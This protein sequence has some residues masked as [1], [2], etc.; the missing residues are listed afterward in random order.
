MTDKVYITTKSPFD[1][2]FDSVEENRNDKKNISEYASPINSVI[3]NVNEST[4]GA[5]EK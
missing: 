1:T 4:K 2:D 5:T 3:G